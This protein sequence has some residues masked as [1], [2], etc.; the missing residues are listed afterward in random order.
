[1]I[2]RVRIMAVL[3]AMVIGGAVTSVWVQG[4]IAAQ[5]GEA[6]LPADVGDL[7]NATTIEIKDSSGT[8]VLRGHFVESPEDDDDVER[9]AALAG[10]G[11]TAKATGEAEIEVS[12][13]NNRLDQEV[14]VSVSNLPPGATYT[15]YIDAKQVG[16]FQTNQTGKGELELTTPA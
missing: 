9:K 2:K 10:S 8:V 3:G 15:V 16:M 5:V 4:V 7:S 13:A 12:R 11:T 1:M 6:S 14:E